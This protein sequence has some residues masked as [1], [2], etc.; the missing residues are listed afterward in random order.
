M[1][2]IAD[3]NRQLLIQLEKAEQHIEILREEKHKI[4]FENSHLS[5]QLKRALENISTFEIR[6]K[7]DDKRLQTVTKKCI[8]RVV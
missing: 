8:V 5:S 3:M 2:R 1:D 7:D 4:S 6:E